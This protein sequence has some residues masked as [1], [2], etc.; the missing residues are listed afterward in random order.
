MNTHYLITVNSINIDLKQVF[1]CLRGLEDSVL[2]NLITMIIIEQYANKKGITISNDEILEEVNNYRMSYQMKSADSFKNYLKDRKINFQSFKNAIK[3]KLLEDKL[4]DTM[5]DKETDAHITENQL[6]FEQVE[7]YNIRLDNEDTANEIKELL[8]DEEMNFPGLAFE[9][10]LDEA[11]RKQGG[12]VGFLTRKD[13]TA[14]IEAAV[15]NAKKGDIVGPYQTKNGYN[16]FMINEFHKPQ[17]D[18]LR[19]RRYIKH[20]L[21]E[22]KIQK[23]ISIADIQCPFYE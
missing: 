20:Q 15:F 3:I 21:F 1:N 11:T 18:D 5:S 23:L 22:A 7:L 17:K 16:I 2:N 4:I 13:M 12:Y 14:E 10:S 19:L 8:D 6:Q 9:H